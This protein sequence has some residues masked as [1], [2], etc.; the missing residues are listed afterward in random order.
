M[1]FFCS[2]QI[3]RRILRKFFDPGQ[4][5]VHISGSLADSKFFGAQENDFSA[6]FKEN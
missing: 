2:I 3:L 6:H 4:K 1:F 5:N